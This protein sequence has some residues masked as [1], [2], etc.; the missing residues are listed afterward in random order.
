LVLLRT[1]NG[2]EDLLSLPYPSFSNIWRTL[3]LESRRSHPPEPLHHRGTVRTLQLSHSLLI[4]C[5]RCHAGLDMCHHRSLG[6][7]LLLQG[8]HKP[9]NGLKK[10]SQL[11]RRWKITLSHGRRMLL[12]SSSLRRCSAWRRRPWNISRKSRTTPR[13]PTS[14]SNSANT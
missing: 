14:H 10:S 9:W 5:W 3:P 11:W 13:P 12:N 4:G 8:L 1:A 2:T 7:C 6:L